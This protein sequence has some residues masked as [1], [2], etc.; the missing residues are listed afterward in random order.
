MKFTWTFLC[1]VV[2]AAALTACK[3]SAPAASEGDSEAEAT[4]AADESA[5]P[6]TTPAAK[7]DIPAPPDVAAVPKDAE[8]SE[9]GLAWKVLQE[10]E[11]KIR[12]SRYDAVILTYTGWTP[13]GRM[14]GSASKIR[15]KLEDLVPGWI[16][17]VQLM[18]PGEKRRFWI[19]GKLAY[20]EAKSG[21]P[22][23]QPERP[24]GMVV[25]DIE[26][27][28]FK[29]GPIPPRAVPEDVAEIPKNAKKSKSGLAWRVLHKGTGKEHPTAKSTVF[30]NYA[31][32]TT[33]GK[34]FDT[35]LALGGGKP[36]GIV[37]GDAIPGW[38]EGLQMIVVGETRRFW[39]PENLAYA[40][41]PGLPRG[42]LV[43]DIQLV[44]F[45]D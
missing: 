32:W 34:M 6:Q 1:C 35:S 12:P 41:Q 36:R 26:L 20:G 43:Y 33:D 14:F 30:V 44:H 42:M 28:E 25:F 10:G 27:I 37:L 39:I 7:P 21:D 4:A 5:K 38:Q 22:N 24:R 8:R 3:S 40:G 2:L 18:L 23:V 15:G 19:P 13:D 45:E 31:G 29:R 17:G 16:E 11:G 9:S